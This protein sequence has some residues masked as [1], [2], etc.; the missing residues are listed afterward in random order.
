MNITARE[1]H[2]ITHLSPQK[3]SHTKRSRSVEAQAKQAK[4]HDKQQDDIGC[5]A[6]ESVKISN[7]RI[8]H[9]TSSLSRYR[10]NADL[11]M[12][13]SRRSTAIKG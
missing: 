1:K 4:E 7:M 11:G 13:E 9:Y 8:G 5:E 10:L 12:D 6:D 3:A 2:Q